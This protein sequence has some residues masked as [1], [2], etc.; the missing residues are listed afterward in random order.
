MWNPKESGGEAKFGSALISCNGEAEVRGCVV[1]PALHSLDHCT[2]SRG[3]TSSSSMTIKDLCTEK[4]IT[5][6]CHNFHIAIPIIYIFLVSPTAQVISQ[7]KHKI[8][9]KTD[10]E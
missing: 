3:N 1:S 5:S 2:E 8:H 4:P 7:N 6:G 10:Q 9:A